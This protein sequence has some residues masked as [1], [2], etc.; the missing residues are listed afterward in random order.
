[1]KKVMR[2]LAALIAGVLLLSVIT[3]CSGEP[4]SIAGKYVK[5]GFPDSYLILNSDGTYR[6][7]ES[8]GLWDETSGE[9]SLKG[10]VL[11]LLWMGEPG[12]LKGAKVEGNRI[13]V[14]YPY[15][16]FET[17]VWVKR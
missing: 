3:G 5:E 1:M 16:F 6:L 14:E 17:E 15:G 12:L 10:K 8:G 7:S 11:E 4:K 13:I 2:C 9:W